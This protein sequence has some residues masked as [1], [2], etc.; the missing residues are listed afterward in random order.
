MEDVYTAIITACGTAVTQVTSA[1]AS[2]MPVIV[3]LGI[4][5]AGVFAVYK[6]VR[7]FFG[8]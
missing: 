3:P 5:V 2:A 4:G 8:R 7:R 6:L 1:F